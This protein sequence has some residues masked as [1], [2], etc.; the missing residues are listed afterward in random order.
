MS[1]RL[2]LLAPRLGRLLCGFWLDVLL[3]LG[4]TVHQRTPVV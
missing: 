3:T 1:D 2:I 4:E